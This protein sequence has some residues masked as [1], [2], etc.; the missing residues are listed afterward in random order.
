MKMRM[1]AVLAAIC[2]IGAT[3]T[4]KWFSIDV[5]SGWPPMETN[6]A[7]L[8]TGWSLVRIRPGEPLLR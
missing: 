7:S 6:M 5:A 4:R 2:H 1:A 3:M 8:L